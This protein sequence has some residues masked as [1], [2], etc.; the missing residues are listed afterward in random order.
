MNIIG[1]DPS[2]NS[3]A[4]CY[5]KDDNINLFSF[6]NIK[7]NNKWI[8]EYESYIH[9]Y[10]HTYKDSKNFTES[11]ILK[12]NN[13][14]SVSDAILENINF[15]D[16]D[17]FME[18]Y[19]YSSK[20]GK[21]IDLVVFSTLLRYKII[22]RTSA[23]LNIVPPS[24]LKSE[25]GKMV[26]EPDKKGYYRNSEGIASGNFDKKHMMSALLDTNNDFDYLKKLN[27]NKNDILS[28][29][30]IPKP[31]DDKNDAVLLSLYG[32]KTINN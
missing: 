11:E 9:F 4:V 18:G 7:P 6:N 1:I 13:Y 23:R 19:S 17:V 16:S 32:Q 30:N 14:D 5:L 22:N 2:L 21:I 31:L 27:E 8:K 28:M 29:R 12:L 10:H 3:T 26:Y 25:I 24:T 20:N 15:D